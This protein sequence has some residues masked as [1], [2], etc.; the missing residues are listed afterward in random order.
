MGSR[1]FFR[2]EGSSNPEG[3][4]PVFDEKILSDFES[5]KIRSSLKTK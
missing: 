5:S 4:R 2:F 1:S 3:K